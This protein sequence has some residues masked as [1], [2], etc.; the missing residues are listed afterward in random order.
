MPATGN[1][2]SWRRSHRNIKLE[3]DE[4]GDRKWLLVVDDTE[5]SA[6]D[7]ARD[8]NIP[9]RQLQELVQ[10]EFETLW[11]QFNLYHTWSLTEAAKQD[12]LLAVQRLVKAGAEIHMQGDRSENNYSALRIAARKGHKLVVHYLLDAEKDRLSR[13]IYT[14]ERLERAVRDGNHEEVERMIP[15]RD[16]ISR[17]LSAKSEALCEAA[18]CG[19][20]ELLQLLS[21]SGGQVNARPNY[22]PYMTALESVAQGGHLPCVRYLLG[23]GA[24]MTPRRSHSSALK[25][26]SAEGFSD[27]VDAL[28]Q[29]GAGPNDDNALHAAAFGGHLEIVNRLVDAG[30]D[31]DADHEYENSFRE[32][33]LTALQEA[34]RGGHLNVVDTLIRKGADVNALPRDRGMTALQAAVASDSPEVVRYLIA[35]GANINAPAEEW[36]RTALQKAAEIGSIAMVNMLLDAGAVLERSAHQDGRDA[37][38]LELAIKGGHLSVAERLLQKV[39]KAGEQEQKYLYN[40]LTLALHTAAF[41]GYEHIVRRLLEVGAPILELDRPA[42]LVPYTASNGHTAIVKMLLDAGAEMDGTS[43]R[44]SRTSH[45]KTALQSAVAGGHVETARLLLEYGAD[46]NAAPARVKSPLHLACR[47]GDVTMV[48]MLLDAGVNIRAVSYSGKTVRRSAE[49]GGSVEILQ[50]LNMREA[51]EHSEGNETNV[52]DVSTIAKRGL[53]SICS[54]LPL[55]VFTIPRWSRRYHSDAFYFHPSLV[56]LEENARGGCPF[57]LFFWKRLG[58]GMISIPQPSKVRLFHN[59]R[60]TDDVAEIWSQIDE[61]Y[62][63]DVE[64]PQRERAD[65]QACVEPFDGK[66]KALPGNTQ[67]AETYQQIVTWLQQC[68]KNHHACTVGSNGR[69]LPTRLIDLTGWGRGKAVKLVE[70]NSIHRD[71]STPYIALSHRWDGQITAVASTT[72]ENILPRLEELTIDTLPRNFVH[73]MEVTHLLKINY[74]WI[75]SLCIL[76]DSKEDWNREAAL[77]SEVYQNSECTISDQSGQTSS[78]GFFCSGDVQ[79]DSVEFRCSSQD[80][81]SSKMVRAVK[82]QPSWVALLAQGPLQ[83]RGWCLQERELSPRVLHYTPSQVLWECRAFKASEGWPAR[84]IS[85]ELSEGYSGY[86]LRILDRIQAQD[87]HEIYTSWLNTVRDY[88]SRS[89]TKYEDTFPALGG[90]ARIVHGY[91]HCDYVAGMWAADLRRSIA[92][93]PGEGPNDDSSSTSRHATYV[94]PT[95]SWAS[96]VGK[97][98]FEQAK[99]LSRDVTDETVAVIDG[100]RITHLTPDPF[101]QI[102]SAELHMTT[103]I[104]TAVLDYYST[105]SY[106]FLRGPHDTVGKWYGQ[107]IFDVKAESESLQVV[108]CIPLFTSDVRGGIGLA[109]VP[110]QGQEHTYRRVGHIWELGMSHFQT[111]ERQS[112]VLI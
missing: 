110:V 97:V 73:A 99:A 103:P 51:L 71:Q 79:N 87:T 57:C 40:P 58:I 37:P 22:H 32:G 95:W 39:D 47:N 46:I 92:W 107:M 90:L 7:L 35:V 27:V 36:G 94:A 54:G 104:L 34:A 86:N 29:A 85:G 100:W 52:L 77:M 53:C 12:D 38:A 55:E 31:I 3:K 56:S 93:V 105:S 70:S 76:Q 83:S 19:N 45:S 64:R 66:V 5:R 72:S 50:L 20:L 108:W 10:L 96:V 80:G 9:E 84:D 74:L 59:S 25:R 41:Q 65:F 88:A 101:G 2:Y 6:L 69:F 1:I 67:S 33:H 60:S 30:A 109:L 49:K 23:H 63:K 21:A 111:L 28:L 4:H 61:P 81:Q 82:T 42:L 98:S 89:L 11:D 106:Y 8:A 13:H 68:I 112:I 91:V 102:A 44:Y 78:M 48:R 15:E 62:P 43:S 14:P 18:G 17:S 16:F 75:D 26:A 24:T